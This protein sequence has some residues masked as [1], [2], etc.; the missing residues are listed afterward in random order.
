MTDGNKTSEGANDAFHRQVKDSYAAAAT[1]WRAGAGVVY[2]QL[3][4]AMV[5]KGL[6]ARWP[7]LERGPILDLC[8]GTGAVSAAF[9]RSSTQLVAADMVHGMLAIDADRRPPAVVCDATA[10]AFRSRCFTAVLVAFG[11]N[12]ATDPVAFLMEAG[13]VTVRGGTIG[14]ST[15][16]D[17]WNHPF[18]AGIDD[19]L[20]GFGF[21][22]PSWHIR[23]KHEVEPTTSTKSALVALADRAGLR[24]S[25][26][27]SMA[28]TLSLTALEVVG[29]RFSMASHADFV[30][31][32]PDSVR[33]EATAAAVGEVNRRWEPVVAPMLVLTAQA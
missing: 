32:L 33:E 31:S 15:F 14:A 21:E 7:G 4:V 20:A 6:D 1:A 29:W 25:A 2:R 26:V 22:P 18:K 16:A 3:A 24:D 27:V 8:A 12:H 23:L 30:A 10:L 11:L 19:V 28:V 13:R 5:R 9:D 17:G